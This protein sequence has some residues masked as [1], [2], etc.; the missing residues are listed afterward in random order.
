MV[1]DAS[2]SRGDIIALITLI[3]TVLL[4]GSAVWVA[5]LIYGRQREDQQRNS[6]DE[7]R[8]HHEM[9]IRKARSEF[10][11]R[12][13]EALASYP[14]PT[15]GTATVTVFPDVNAGDREERRGV[16]KSAMDRAYR[17]LVDVDGSSDF[18]HT[19]KAAYA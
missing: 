13:D 7:Q 3:V 2:W 9:T 17:E 6:E 1:S 11:V 14:V 10:M 19:A 15:R 8:R 12:L 18:A 4:G 16:Q 5:F